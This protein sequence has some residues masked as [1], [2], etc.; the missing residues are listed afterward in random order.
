M[1]WTPAERLHGIQESVIR[2]MTR[3]ALKHNAIN[4]SQGLPDFPPPPEVLQAAQAA[5]VEGYNQYSITWGL[6]ETR[7][8]IAQKIHR[9]YGVDVDPEYHVT[10][11][12]GV[13]EAI[14]AA[15][16]SVVNPGDEVILFEPAHE[17]FVPAIRFAG[18]KPIFIPLLPPAFEV[19]VDALRKAFGPRTRAVLVNTPHNPTGKVFSAEEL[20]MIGELAETWDAVI[21]TDEIYEHIIYDGRQH[22]SPLTLTGLEQR[23][24]SLGG[25]S[26]TYA[27]TGW[28]LGYAISLNPTLSTALRTVHD[29]LTICAPTPLQKAAVVA[30][31][32]PTSYYEDLVKGYTQRRAV[33]MRSLHNAGFI[34]HPPQGSY[35]VLADFRALGWRG[36]AMSFAR[37][38]TTAVGVAVV[39][40]S[41][42]YYT[43]GLGETT[44]R[45]AFPK[46]VE[47]L[48]EAG[49]RLQRAVDLLKNRG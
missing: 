16:F 39:P 45:F 7:S 2:E 46:R 20:R 8:A 23:V 28:R 41:A 49:Q 42:F 19:D 24:I 33:M 43:P 37:W 10:V 6:P 15:V 17:N 21:I 13:S 4:L 18:G 29:Y 47:T 12:C 22:V 34:A 36:D 31:N 25:L 26:K 5:L 30:L 32:L 48:E 44:V 3:L 14:M 1:N 38:L 27:M 35:Y 9:F 40:G 11:T